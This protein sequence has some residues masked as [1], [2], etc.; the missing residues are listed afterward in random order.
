MMN[1][2]GQPARLPGSTSGYAL[3]SH[4]FGQTLAL[5]TSEAPGSQP[6][7]CGTPSAAPAQAVAATVALRLADSLVPQR[8]R[9]SY[10]GA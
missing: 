10:C 5:L 3:G 7:H 4:V 6:S 2:R 1:A 8:M 9:S